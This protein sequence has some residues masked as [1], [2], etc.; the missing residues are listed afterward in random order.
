M[1]EYQTVDDSIDAQAESIPD[2]SA[3]VGD[4]Q[5][6]GSDNRSDNHR[7]LERSLNS[8]PADRR[9]TNGQFRS[10]APTRG[11][12]PDDY[13]KSYVAHHR[14]Y[15]KTL[16]PD[17]RGY[18]SQREQEAHGRISELG[19]GVATYRQVSERYQHA[20]PQGMPHHVAYEHM[21]AAAEAMEREPEKAFRYLAQHYNLDLRKLAG[22]SGGPSEA[23]LRLSVDKFAKD[24]EFFA[25]LED[26]IVDQIRVIRAREPNASTEDVLQRAYDRAARINQK[27]STAI[28]TKRRATE[29]Q[30]RAEATRKKGDEA[31]RAARINVRSSPASVHRSGRSWEETLEAAADNAFRR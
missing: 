3:P 21:L 28:E 25:D 2:N 17:F 24:K 16:A 11:D 1:S 4:Y 18:L 6:R 15:W 14:D 23:T 12:E 22:D 19:Q 29:E 7:Q 9:G 8:P 10:N 13:P 27:V 31:R 30:E 26:D 5:D 20:I